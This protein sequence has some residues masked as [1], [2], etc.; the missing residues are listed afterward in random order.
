MFELRWVYPDNLCNPDVL[1]YRYKEF[2]HNAHGEN[3]RM[4]EWSEWKDVP[5]IH[6]LDV[7]KK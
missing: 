6:H 2:Y 3:L 4:L 7:K 5:S 1:Q